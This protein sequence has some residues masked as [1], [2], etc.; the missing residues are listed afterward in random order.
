MESVET[1][2]RNRCSTSGLAAAR[3]V[4]DLSGLDSFAGPDTAVVVWVDGRGTTGNQRREGC[5]SS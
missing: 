3:T 2:L 1:P 5:D 4:G